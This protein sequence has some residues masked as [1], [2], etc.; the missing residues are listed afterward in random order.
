M[1][2]D[3]GRTHESKRSPTDT[4][5]S[6]HVTMTVGGYAHGFSAGQFARVM[7]ACS[8][9]GTWRM[10]VTMLTRN[11]THRQNTSHRI[12]VLEEDVRG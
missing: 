3:G 7:G 2:Q 8:M 9:R 4:I 6:L 12:K 11:T 5:W 10:A 1:P